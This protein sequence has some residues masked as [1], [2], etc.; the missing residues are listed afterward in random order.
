[1][2]KRKKEEEQAKLR[3]R[4]TRC[5]GSKLIAGTVCAAQQASQHGLAVVAQPDTTGG[6]VGVFLLFQH[7]LNRNRAVAVALLFSC[8]VVNL[9]VRLSCHCWPAI[10]YYYRFTTATRHTRYIKPGPHTVTHKEQHMSKERAR[11]SHSVNFRL[12]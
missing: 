1:M 3:P 6:N 5:G 9:S 10:L 4:G 12:N 7:Y 8:H 11:D 2:C